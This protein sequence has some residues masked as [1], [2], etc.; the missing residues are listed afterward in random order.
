VNEIAQKQI[1]AFLKNIEA[2]Q[3]SEKMLALAIVL[4]GLLL[5][6]LSLFF[7]PARLKLDLLVSQINNVERQIQ[8]QQ[9]AYAAMEELSKEDPNKFANDRIQVIAR[10]Q[11]QLDQQIANLAGDLVS[12]NQMTTILTSVLE[13]QAGLELV[14]FQNKTATPLRVGFAN[15]S[16]V[17]EQ[18]GAVNFDE[19]EEDEISGQL[20][21]HGLIIEFQ[22]GFFNTLKYLRFLEEITGSFFWDAIS[23]R[24]L[25]WPDAHVTLEI[26]TLS[27]DE[28]FIGV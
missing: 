5:T 19:L 14:H 2:R 16:Q 7:D 4:V 23:F 20:Y 17:L 21:Q 10:E 1:N 26:H 24:Q 15:A 28:G 6:W 18:T 13:R 12:P 9:T 22:G 11:Q 3:Q 8:A 27:T 25:E